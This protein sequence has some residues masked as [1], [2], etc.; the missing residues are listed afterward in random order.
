MAC[1]E[2]CGGRG[3]TF[4]EI[5]A[6]M[7]FMAIVIPVTVRGVSL[8]N[9]MGVM[10]ER[11]RVATELASLKLNE[12]FLDDSWREGNKEGNFDD[13]GDASL[14]QYRWTLEITPW[15]DDVMRL[16][17]VKV[18]YKVQNVE[19]SVSLGTLAIAEESSQS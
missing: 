2:R 18:F 17:V 10:A 16:I 14:S 7:L 11:K 15:T 6:A 5:L 13:T 4:A 3:F 12:V 1:S 9:R 8:A 19:Y